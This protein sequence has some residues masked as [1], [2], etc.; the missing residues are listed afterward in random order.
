MIYY[1]KFIVFIIFVVEP[2]PQKVFQEYLIE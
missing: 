1:F 2:I